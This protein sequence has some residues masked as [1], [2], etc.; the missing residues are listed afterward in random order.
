MI[1]KAQEV[2]ARSVNADLE[3]LPLYN[4]VDFAFDVARAKLDGR[5]PVCVNHVSDRMYYFLS[6]EATVTIGKKTY[7][8]RAGDTVIIR[9][10]ECHGLL[11]SAEYLVV[12]SPSFK[13]ENESWL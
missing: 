2:A 9:K 10:G 1:V 11:G 3:I 7:T 4:E 5:H 13:P 6:G 8:A 12:T